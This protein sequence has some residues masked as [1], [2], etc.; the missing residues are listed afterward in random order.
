MLLNDAKTIISQD[1]LCHGACQ[2]SLKVKFSESRRAMSPLTV[3]LRMDHSFFLSRLY[4]Q[5]TRAL[6]VVVLFHFFLSL[7]LQECGSEEGVS[8]C[9]KHEQQGKQYNA[10]ISH[11]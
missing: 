5:T 9:F 3:H 6:V 4:F 1:T 7:H 10:G 8:L 11:F 2:I